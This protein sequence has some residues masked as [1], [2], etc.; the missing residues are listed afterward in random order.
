[1][2]LIFLVY[3]FCEHE[4]ITEA[5]CAFSKP[6]RAEAFAEKCNEYEKTREPFPENDDDD[7]I[8]YPWVERQ[9]LWRKNHPAGEYRDESN[10][11]VKKID[12]DPVIGDNK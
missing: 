8:F 9:D 4:G 11:G 6:R 2:R 5:I 7:E 10:F 1:M 12:L 3:G